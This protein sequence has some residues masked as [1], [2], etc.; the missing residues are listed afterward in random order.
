MWMRSGGNP[1]RFV[2]F[3]RPCMWDKWREFDVGC[4]PMDAEQQNHHRTH[5]IT[6]THGGSMGVPQGQP[7]WE[8]VSMA[9]DQSVVVKIVSESCV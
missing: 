9:C 4:V 6:R 2:R 8:T 7:S 1:G 5:L 3:T